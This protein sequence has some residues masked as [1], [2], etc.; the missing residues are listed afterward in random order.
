MP[1]G[2]TNAQIVGHRQVGSEFDVGPA[3]GERLLAALVP[4]ARIA[5]DATNV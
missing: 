3:F 5:V 2:G 4:D 1:A